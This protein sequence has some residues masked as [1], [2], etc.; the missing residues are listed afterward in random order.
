M[1]GSIKGKDEDSTADMP[2]KGFSDLDLI[3]RALAIYRPDIGLSLHRAFEARHV[4]QEDMKSPVLDLGCN[5]GLFD[6]LWRGFC[7]ETVHIT[8]CDMNRAD[9]D[10]AIE[11]R[12]IDEAIVT[13]GRCLPLKDSCMNT[14]IANSV[15]THVP[16]VDRLLEEVSRVL[17]P[18]GKFLFSV[19]GPIFEN[20]T[21]ISR[22]CR[23]NRKWL[24]SQVAAMASG[25]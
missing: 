23:Q 19:P 18:G 22:S 14:V 11:T 15:L 25:R 4:L 8:G 1:T 16:E 21:G 24:R 6:L 5:D 2:R 12:T 10:R 20:Q 13:D 3:A 17:R 9:L 7:P